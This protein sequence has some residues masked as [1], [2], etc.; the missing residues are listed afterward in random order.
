MSRVALITGGSRGIGLGIAKKLAEEGFNLAINGVREEASVR[1]ALE[2]L[3]SLGARVEYLQ[4]NIA[5]REDRE[6]IISGLIAKF[7]KIDVLV[8]NAGVAPRTRSDIFDIT[9]EDFDHLMDIN[10]R[11][12]FFLTQAI[13]KWMAELKMNKPDSDISIVTITSISAEVASTTRASYCMSKSA[14]SMLSKVLAV[15]MA[16]FGIPVYE[17]RPGVIETDM[18][19]KVRET[20]H[21]GVKN[22]MTLEPRMGVPEDIGKVVA[23]LVK[24]DLPY[25]TGQVISVDGGMTIARM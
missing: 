7:G 9:E 24:G 13:A 23:A 20:Y 17:I 15:K 10:L 8:N 6:S 2:S 4:G 3:R 19:E 5:S 1:E 12:T 25:S 16:E 21:Q 18:I 22:G 11:G 14:L